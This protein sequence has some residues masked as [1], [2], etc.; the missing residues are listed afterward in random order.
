MQGDR[1]VEVHQNNSGLPTPTRRTSGPNQIQ[2]KQ[3]IKI[4]KLNLNKF[5]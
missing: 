5:K 3:K 2:E 4:L 1:V